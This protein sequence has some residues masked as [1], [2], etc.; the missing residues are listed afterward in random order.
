M[1]KMAMT[2]NP[3]CVV[4]KLLYPPYKPNGKDGRDA[5]AVSFSP[6]KNRCVKL[7]RKHD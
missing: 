6:L 7:E 1:I 4:F 3:K 5:K 2:K